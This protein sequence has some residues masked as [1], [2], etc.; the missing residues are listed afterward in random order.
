MGKNDRETVKAMDNEIVIPVVHEEV[1]A[2]TRK[3]KTGAVRIQKT[4]HEQREMID[5]TLVRESVDV[6][7]I[8]KNEKV[9]GPQPVR[10]EGD[11]I[12]VPVVEEVLRVERDWILREEVRIKR[13]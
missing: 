6:Q 12:I 13:F 4:T 5:Q 8:V 11:T 3:V 9:D 1:E 2:D 10:E 7:R